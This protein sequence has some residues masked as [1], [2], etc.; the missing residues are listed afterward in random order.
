MQPLPPL[1]DGLIVVVL[2]EVPAE[3]VLESVF[4]EEVP[5]DVRAEEA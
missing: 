5:E 4:A 1:K 3:D 2:K